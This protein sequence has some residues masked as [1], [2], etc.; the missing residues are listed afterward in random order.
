MTVIN[1][2]CI[3]VNIF[4]LAVIVPVL[5]WLIGVYLMK[6]KSI[7]D[8]VGFLLAPKCTFVGFLSDEDWS[9]EE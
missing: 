2:S 7:I 5:A 3:S 9:G 8:A 4:K 6:E 1:C